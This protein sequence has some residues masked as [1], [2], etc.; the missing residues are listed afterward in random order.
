M[1][2][3][4]RRS[5]VDYQQ[6]FARA[7]DYKKENVTAELRTSRM[8]RD[9]RDLDKLREN[10][11]ETTDPFDPTLDSD[12]FFSIASGKSASDKTAHFF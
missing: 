12:Y 9:G 1:G 6:R 8:K 10:V 3:K 5:D 4:P 7:L 11:K 2:V